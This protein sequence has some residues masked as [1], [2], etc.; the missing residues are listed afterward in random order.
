MGGAVVSSWMKARDG[1]P[2][3]CSCEMILVVGRGGGV[4]AVGAIVGVSTWSGD[5]MVS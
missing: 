5:R 3:V 2:E 1:S 4:R